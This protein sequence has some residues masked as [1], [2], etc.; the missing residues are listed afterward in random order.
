MK[1]DILKK[2][3]ITSFTVLFSGFLCA[4]CFAQEEVMTLGHLNSFSGGTSLY[5]EDSKRGIELAIDEINASGGVEV[6]GKKYKVAVIHLDN[7]YQAAPGVASYRRLVDMHKVKFIH[8]MGTVPG[9]AIMQYNEK[10]GVLL[11]IISPTETLNQLGNKLVL[12]QVVRP[13][14]Y[15]VPVVAEAWKR[16]CKNMCIIA[17]DSDFGRE[18]TQIVKASFEKLGGKVK[19]IEY[20]QA[21]IGVDFMSILTKLKGYNPDS[22]YVITVEEPG[23]RIAKQAR[24]LGY[25]GRM[26]FT[27]HF[28][29]KSID[30][31]GLSKLEGTLFTGSVST[32]SSVP[33]EGTPQGIMDYRARYLA[34]YPGTYLSSTG[35]YGYNFVYY[36]TEAMKLAGTTTDAYKVRSM[37]DKSIKNLKM[38]KHGGF[39]KGGRAYG[40]PVF[41]MAIDNG[42]PQIVG[43]ASFPKSMAAQGE[44]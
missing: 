39:T 2:L 23:I 19:G 32:L 44:K 40:Q 1:N 42:K 13:S 17:E 20:V 36:V 24:E 18:H 28:K 11:D 10:D 25:R 6:K 38:V 21:N 41:V 30:S 35:C 12:N 7:K 8:N 26:L 34:K 31:I 15:D 4:E 37:C 16:G 27:E 29:Q 43:A 9:R 33:V 5:G 14:G 22:L 3:I